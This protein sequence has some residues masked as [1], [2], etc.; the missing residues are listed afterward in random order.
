MK[1]RE[2]AAK[3]MGAHYR[4][5]KSTPTA[6]LAPL[7]KILATSL[8]ISRLPIAHPAAWPLS[9]TVYPSGYEV[10]TSSPPRLSILNRAAPR[11]PMATIVT[12]TIVTLAMS[13]NHL[14]VVLYYRSS[15]A[16]SLV[17]RET[18]PRRRS[19]R[20][21]RRQKIYIL[22]PVYFISYFS[23][24]NKSVLLLKGES[25]LSRDRVNAGFRPLKR[26]RRHR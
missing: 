5:Q 20:K 1:G 19:P 11:V 9:Q 16:K 10:S 8:A 17:R 13:F 15:R 25:C 12:R 7:P 23:A 4:P 18:L 21:A 22:F 2:R 3:T 24:L 14:T 6:M 26:R